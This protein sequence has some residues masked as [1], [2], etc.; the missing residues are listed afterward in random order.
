[1]EEV[2]MVLFT[3]LSMILLYIVLCVAIDIIVLAAIV[4][5]I[6]LAAIVEARFLEIR[7]KAE[8]TSIGI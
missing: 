6:V 7:K 4:L 2:E 5:F 8:I 3:V 1:M